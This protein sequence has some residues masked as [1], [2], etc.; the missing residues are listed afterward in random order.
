MDRITSSLIRQFSND[1][2]LHLADDSILFEYSIISLS[3]YGYKIKDISLD[4]YN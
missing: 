2:E 1:Y 3:N 4:L